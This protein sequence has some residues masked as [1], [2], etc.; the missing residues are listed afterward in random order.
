MSCRYGEFPELFWDLRADET[1]DYEHPSVIARVIT[2]GSTAAIA[3][4]VSLDV[5]RRELENLPVPEHT[6][7]FWRTVLDLAPPSASSGAA[8]GA[9]AHS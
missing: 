2:R 6:R 1:V 8:F 4:L 7:R 5:L 3:R 9:D